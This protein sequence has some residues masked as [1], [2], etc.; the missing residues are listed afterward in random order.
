MENEYSEGPDL[1][2]PERYWDF[3]RQIDK[4]SDIYSD[5]EGLADPQRVLPLLEDDDIAEAIANNA[6]EALPG[7][8]LRDMLLHFAYEN[9]D[10]AD[11]E[12]ARGEAIVFLDTVAW[13]FQARF[14]IRIRDTE[15]GRNEGIPGF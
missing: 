6:S 13:L 9:L 5:L 4:V 8:L 11:H 12:T 7:E 2:N 15:M 10:Q 14:W 3:A 1:E